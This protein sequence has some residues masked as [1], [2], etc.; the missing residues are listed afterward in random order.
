MGTLYEKASD[1]VYRQADAVLREHHGRL[2]TALVTIDFIFAHAP[3]DEKGFTTGPAIKWHGHAAAGLCKILSV[4]DRAMGR[5]DAEIILDGDKWNDWDEEKQN[6]LIDHEL[7]HIELCV[8]Q[9][10]ILKRDDL[11]RP[12]LR[13][14]KHDWEFG[15]F[16]EVARRHGHHSFECANAKTLMDADG[17]F[18]W[19]YLFN[20]TPAVEKETVNA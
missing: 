5:G 3:V 11:D 9:M 20:A 4:K 7:T 10:G 15:F 1:K 6:A 18:F 12:K 2:A 16:A 13:M 19:P 17:Q 8:N 14:R